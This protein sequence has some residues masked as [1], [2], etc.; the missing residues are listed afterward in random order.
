MELARQTSFRLGIASVDPASRSVSWPG[1]ER[2]IE[3]RAMQVLVALTQA[4]GEV[5]TRDQLIAECWGG[6]NVSDDAV[7]RIISQLRRLAR[8]IGPDAFAVE[9]ITKVGFRLTAARAE[10]TAAPAPAAT[11][12]RRA[13]LLA[14]L[15]AA[16]AAGGG[17][18]AYRRSQQSRAPGYTVLAVL[19]FETLSAGQDAGFFA[20]GVTRQIR[21]E[22]SRIGGLRV[23][24][25]PSSASVKAQRLQAREA[26]A[27]LGVSLLVQ[28]SVQQDGNRVRVTSALIDARDGGTLWSQTQEADADALFATQDA[29]SGA[30][31]REVVARLGAAPAALPPPRPRDSRAYRLVQEG[32]DQLEASRA[33]RMAD[34]TAAAFA[35]ADRA[36]AVAQQALAIDPR[37]TGALVLIAQLTRSGWT[38]AMAAEPLTPDQRVAASIDYVTRALAIDPNDPA[39]LTALGDYYR[40]YL[41]RW[42]EAER[43]L[44]K[45]LAINASHPEAHW[46][47][48][49]LLGTTGRVQDGLAH[50]RILFQLDPE[51]TWRRVALPRLLY[52]AG[53]RTGTF[54]CYDIE[55]AETPANLFLIS[56]IYLVRLIENDAAGIDALAARVRGLNRGKPLDPGL[57]DLLARLHDAAEAIRGRPSPFL[58]KVDADVRAYDIAPTGP[59][60]TG[61]RAGVD[62]LYIHAMEYAWAGAT[63]KAI[64]MLG[65]ALAGHSVYWP[66][67]LPYGPAP[68]PDAVRRDTG[69]A[70]LWRRDPALVELIAMRRRSI[71]ASA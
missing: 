54:R 53:D 38:R 66:A 14:G 7:S 67:T 21:D 3:P 51:T 5:V 24:A 60:S 31:L 12:S 57:A 34:R 43:L 36:F 35:A 59:A 62:T 13:T 30:L 56:E 61:A 2:T 69:Y 11:L 29:V 15:A 55:L 45:A 49:Y 4:G 9:T 48:A 25:E 42:A 18:F 23:I 32:Q 33:A 22:L 52:L 44:R 20:S 58:A 46:S 63:G 26:A 41:W 17:G 1:G 6:A 27:R 47:L 40:R 65:R 39:S 64:A 68:F 50:A 37:D 16:A 71:R 28:G 8:E 19:P 10:S 70:A